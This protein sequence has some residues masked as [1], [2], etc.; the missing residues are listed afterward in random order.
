MRSGEEPFE[1]W[2]RFLPAH[3]TAVSTLDRLLLPH[4]VTD[5]VRTESAS[6]RQTDSPCDD[7]L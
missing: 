6:K 2:E 4:Q 3:T 7:S 1:P 5:G